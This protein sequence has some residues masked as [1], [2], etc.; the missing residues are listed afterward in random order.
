MVGASRSVKRAAETRSDGDVKVFMSAG[1]KG[2]NEIWLA[3]CFDVRVC[4]VVLCFCYERASEPSTVMILADDSSTD[5]FH[6]ASMQRLGKCS[7]RSGF[8]GVVSHLVRDLAV[9]WQLD[10]SFVLH[11]W[12]GTYL[13]Y[14]RRYLGT[15]EQHSA[16]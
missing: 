14:L 12:G 8:M 11:A 9:P 6:R 1:M 5:Q 2:V 3:L 7:G 4:C 16:V 10:V 15:L 13:R